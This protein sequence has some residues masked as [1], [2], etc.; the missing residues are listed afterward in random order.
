M[1]AKE[2]NELSVLILNINSRS[3]SS[4]G[5]YRNIERSISG[6][7][8]CYLILLAELLDIIYNKEKIIFD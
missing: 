6:I 3:L 8:V 2:N 1:R 4:I 7:L 5:M